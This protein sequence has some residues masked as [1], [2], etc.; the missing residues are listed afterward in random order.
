MWIQANRNFGRLLLGL[1]LSV[2]LA[3]SVIPSSYA[4]E[5]FRRFT[6]GTY[7][8][9]PS[10]PALQ[11]SQF[12]LEAKFRI[13]GDLSDRGYLVSKG[14]SDGGYVHRDQNYAL[15]LMQY[16]GVAGGFKATDGTY[17]YINS[18]AVSSNAWHVA[19][20]VYDGSKLFLLVDGVLANSTT[21]AKNVDTSDSG[22]LRIGANAQKLG[23]F[24]VG[25]LD[26]VKVMDRSTYKVRY[27]NSFDTG[28]SPSPGPIPKPT[29]GPTPTPSPSGDCSN[30]PMS[31]LRGV[32]FVDPVLT[33]SE[34]GNSVKAPVSYVEDSLKRLHSYGF[35][36]IRVHYYWESYVYNPADFMNRLDL[37]ART[38]QEHDICVVF[39]NHHW[40]TSSYW[41]TDTGLGGKGIG[42]PAF[43]VKSFPSKATYSQTAG[44]F[45]DALLSNSLVIDGRKIWDIQAEFLTKVV[46]RVDKY[47]SVAAYEI[48]NEP[49]LWSKDQYDKLGNYHTFMAQKI[50]AVSD[51]RIV[52]DRETAHDFMR[53]PTMEYKILPRGVSKIVY[54]PHLYAAPT[55]ASGGE[56]QVSNIKKWSQDWGVEIMIGEFSAH[57]QADM[58]AFLKAWKDAG[59]GWTY[60]KWSKAT[61]TRPDHLGNV[62][63]ES[64]TVPK[65]EALK[66]LLNSYNTIY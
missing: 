50:R 54:G 36:L 1:T 9:V 49:H 51:K 46:K 52:F 64:G 65:T 13:T 42:F 25:D 10:S 48:L 21:I 38:A 45:W 34:S 2:L 39:D 26:Y 15:Y 16:G 5:S 14:A 47:D 23:T 11:L 20:L 22:P 6:G 37:I 44:P 27:Y 35:N 12:T 43:V 31:Q 19:R 53:D 18:K 60:W 61:G 59:F 41:K 17:H 29:P 66:Y 3:A 63:Y 40:F 55:E 57:S 7:I 56:K 8:D 58:N 62:V 32:A 24:F 28:A 30:I 4:A 33:R